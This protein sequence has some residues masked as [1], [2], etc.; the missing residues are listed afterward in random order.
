MV[1]A[2]ANDHHGV[3]R[4]NKIKNY[5]EKKGYKVIDIGT[6]STEIV[7]YP[8][9]AFK[10]GKLVQN[11]EADLGILLCG[12]GI[13]MSIAAN[14]LKGIRCAKIDNVND[15]KLAKEH[16]NANVLAMSSTKSM[17][18][19]KDMLDVFFKTKMN[20]LERYQ[21]RNDMLDNYAEDINN[22]N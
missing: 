22:D 6:D 7:D 19:V 12:T 4:K 2:I 5:L 21:R 3:E 16:N 11:K 9:Y 1:I 18:V 14:K 20:S 15:A 8:E 17:F 10:V 13:G